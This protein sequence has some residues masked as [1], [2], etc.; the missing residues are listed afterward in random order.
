MLGQYIFL[1]HLLPRVQTWS[2]L[3]HCVTTPALCHNSSTVSQLQH[4][5]TTPALC[6]NSSTVSQ[7]QHWV[8]TPAPGGLNTAGL[9]ISQVLHLF[10]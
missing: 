7:L 4:C 5:V 8:T 10:P 1:G 9:L 6:H 2:Q 3:Q